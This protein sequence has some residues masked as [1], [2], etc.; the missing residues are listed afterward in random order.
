MARIALCCFTLTLSI[1]PASPDDNVASDRIA[2]PQMVPEGIERMSNGP[3]NDKES[4]FPKFEDVTK[5]M[6]ANKGLFTLW[7]FPP[8]AKD[9]DGEK[10]LCQI[11]KPFLGETFILSISYSGGGFY[12]GQPLEE[13]VVKWDLLERQLLLIEPE[14]RFVVDSTSTIGEVVQRTYPEH[15]RTAVP[16][17]TTTAQGDVLFDMGAML[18]SDF[19]D[20]G[21]MTFG[22]GGRINP[23][24]SK[25]ITKKAF[26]Y[27]MEIGVELA[28]SRQSPPGSYDK[29]MV[30][31]SFWKLPQ[32][33][34][35]TRVADDRVGYFVTANQD[36]G[37]PHDARDIYNRYV[38]RWQLEKRD[39][40][41]PLCE[42]KKPITFYIEKT[43]P[44]RF[45]RAVRDGILEWNKA[46]E[47][48]GFVNAIEVR[49]Q[50]ADNEWKDL[51]PEDMRYSFFRWIVT[52]GSFAR[53]PRRANPFTGQIYDADIV[54]D[55]S[56]VRTLEAEAERMLPSDT[57][58]R[59]TT[60]PAL[61]AFLDSHPE[62]R[63]PERAWEGAVIGEDTDAEL[64][65]AIRQRM[66]ERGLHLCDYARGAK[67]QLAFG[68]ALLT[69]QPKEVIDRLLDEVVKDLVTHEVGHTLGLR[70]NFKAS[71]VYS[72][73]EM[74]RRRES[75]EATC[76][77]V[78]DY[79]PVLFF[80]DKALDGHF[81]MPTIGPY[82]YW[83]IEYGYRVYDGSYTRADADGK[84][85]SQPEASADAE[86]STGELQATPAADTSSSTSASSDT[87][88]DVDNEAAEGPKVE[89]PEEKPAAVA[90][91][92]GISVEGKT[93][94][95]E[96]LDQLPSDVKEMLAARADKEAAEEAPPGKKPAKP[97]FTGPDA[98]ERG[99]LHAIASRAAEPELAYASDEDATF[100]GPDPRTNLFDA[101]SDPIEWARTRIELID[102]RLKDIL[103]WGVKDTES[104]YHLRRAFVVLLVEKTFVLDF[105]GRYIGGQYT[106][107]SHRG[108]PDAPPP[109]KLVSGKQQREALAFIE[110]HLY[111]DQFFSVPPEVLNHLA[112]SRWW[113]HGTYVDFVV[114]FP[115]HDFTGFLQWWNLS[116]RLFPNTLRRIH[117]NELKTNDQDKL[118]ASEYIKRMETACWSEVDNVAR[119]SNGVWSDASPYVSGIR[120]SLQRE[121]LNLIERLVRSRPGIL[122]SPD[123]HAMVQ[124]SLRLLTLRIDAVVATGKLDF[125]TLAHLTSCKSRIERMLEPRLDEYGT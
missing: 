120:R 51:D 37:K 108:D 76:G 107:R 47:K 105:V 94:S 85:E 78:M 5:D 122:V 24:L 60:D 29:R 42:P 52:G 72:V 21:W 34:Y 81:V 13:H 99:M 95:K 111:S 59:D 57:M 46:F 33:G 124:H 20:I 123:I 115:I 58:R 16:V 91:T 10:L 73:E 114:D 35:Q 41:L 87:P 64:R 61:S 38:D 67:H 2:I 25:W 4:K 23:T 31:F 104:W 36:W 7:S 1:L 18:K 19:A 70:H 82:D 98:G 112:V 102:D 8:D 30:H 74:K 3:A 109:F 80:K 48:V 56:L 27:N 55:D 68:R 49:Q 113:H 96:V 54:F 65:R 121:Y 92:G 12:T 116:A 45:R 118:T 50:T 86:T 69:N 103:E 40:S 39:P 43:V 28:V 6:E 63:R 26:E 79:N 89:T 77:S 14:S 84:D 93:I 88:Q 11:P 106:N 22:Q 9:K 32:T 53:G 83:A 62:W 119:A 75:G 125:A 71:S 90:D 17:V 66:K 15:I 97:A 100:L 117:D 101:G 110:R 44:V